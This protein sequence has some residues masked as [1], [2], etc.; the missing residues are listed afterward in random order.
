MKNWQNELPICLFGR[1]R[2]EPFTEEQLKQATEEQSNERTTGE[3]QSEVRLAEVGEEETRRSRQGED[4]R[5]EQLQPQFQD[6]PLGVSVG[7]QPVRPNIRKN[8]S[9]QTPHSKSK[10]KYELLNSNFAKKKRNKLTPSARLNLKEH[11]KKGRLKTPKQRPTI[12]STRKVDAIYEKSKRSVRQIYSNMKDYDSFK[13]NPKNLAEIRKKLNLTGGYSET[14]SGK[15]KNYGT[16]N[17]NQSQQNASR[18]RQKNQTDF[19]FKPTPGAFL[20]NQSREGGQIRIEQNTKEGLS[21]KRLFEKEEFSMKSSKKFSKSNKKKNEKLKKQLFNQN[22]K[23]SG[24]LANQKMI[25]LRG[26]KGNFSKAGNKFTSSRMINQK[27]LNY[28]NFQSYRGY[29]HSG[30]QKEKQFNSNQFKEE[31]LD[32]REAME[33]FAEYIAEG[34]SNQDKKKLEVVR[35]K[36]SFSAQV[37]PKIKT[38]SY[39]PKNM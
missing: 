5:V 17:S 16:N 31:K 9:T 6:Q 25:S 21:D 12:S 19:H 7:V 24:R 10:L 15:G 39:F 26:I 14:V 37:S 1:K 20:K 33:K 22:P 11:I 4:G 32:T 35:K 28:E 36:A 2:K 38:S 27:L 30:N 29:D 3:L 8:L 34:R 23:N 18:P 13:E